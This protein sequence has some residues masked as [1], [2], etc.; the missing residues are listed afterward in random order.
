MDR[1]N[2]LIGAL[3]GAALGAIVGSLVRTDK[4]RQLVNS[5]T[6]SIKNATNRV[7]EYAKQN[8][9]GMKTEVTEDSYTL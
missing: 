5:A 1:N 6:E 8:I 9:P 2:I 4:G 3:A 7:S